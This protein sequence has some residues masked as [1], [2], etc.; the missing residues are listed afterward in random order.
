MSCDVFHRYWILHGQ[1]MTLTFHA[2]FVNQYAAISRKSWRTEIKNKLQEFKSIP[3]LQMQCKCGHR[4]WQLFGPFLGLA[5]GEP[6]SSQHQVRRHPFPGRQ[7]A[8]IGKLRQNH[9]ENADIQ[10]KFLSS[11]LQEHIP[12]AQIGQIY[13]VGLEKKFDLEQMAVG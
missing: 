12:P 6:I 8:R 11:L 4:A 13:E 5:I 7:P 3:H 2:R 9:L 1:S 10:H